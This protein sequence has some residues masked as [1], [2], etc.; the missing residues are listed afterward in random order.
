MVA[1]IPHNLSNSNNVW[2]VSVEPLRS[3]AR[4]NDGRLL[5]WLLVGGA[6][7]LFLLEGTSVVNLLR[8]RSDAVYLHRFAR[9]SNE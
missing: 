5:I 3:G 8:V 1:Q 4:V 6:A 7:F 9:R 2:G